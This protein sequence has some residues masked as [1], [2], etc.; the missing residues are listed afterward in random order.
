MRR[1][2]REPSEAGEVLPGHHHAHAR[3][4]P[5]F[6]HIDALDD[7]VRDRAALEHP[8]EQVR[9]ELHVIHVG[10]CARHLLPSLAALR[11]GADDGMLAAGSRMLEADS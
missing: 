6:A 2:F 7:A 11:A 3:Q 5:S 4:R 8:V 1:S 9:P 10:G